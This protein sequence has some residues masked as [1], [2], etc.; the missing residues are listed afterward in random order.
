MGL[1][2]DIL[3]IRTK[4]SHI[5]STFNSTY[6]R[7]LCCAPHL[8]LPL[9][10]SASMTGPCSSSYNGSSLLLYEPGYRSECLCTVTPI[11]LSWIGME[12]I[13]LAV[14]AVRDAEA[15]RAL[16]LT[17]T[18]VSVKERGGS[19]Y[20]SEVPKFVRARYILVAAITI[21]IT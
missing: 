2:R 5:L 3:S 10:T 13:G 15:S 6:K 1:I 21:M 17:S 4:H 20:I 12:E 18:T 11:R 8:S 14:D 7:Y 16:E 9:S 19:S